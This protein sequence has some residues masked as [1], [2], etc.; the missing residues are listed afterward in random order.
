MT[1]WRPTFVT[2]PTIPPFKWPNSAAQYEVGGP[3][4]PTTAFEPWYV[5]HAQAAGL[6]WTTGAVTVFDE[7]GAYR[8]TRTRTGSPLNVAGP[9]SGATTAHVQLVSPSLVNRALVGL[10][11][12]GHAVTAELEIR[13]LPEPRASP[14]LVVALSLL[15]AL[16]RRRPRR[17]SA[18]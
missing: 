18:G 16:G 1:G 9:F 8:T 17:A 15:G 14:V 2:T 4:P 13:F 7:L 5:P 11:T 12:L 6:G 3:L 10:T